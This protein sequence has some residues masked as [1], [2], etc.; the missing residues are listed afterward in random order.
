MKLKIYLFKSVTSTNDVALKKIKK[1]FAN[2]IIIAK[3]Q[4]KGRGR[5][6]KNWISMKNNLFMSIFFK[7]KSKIELKKLTYKIC[8][9]VQESLKKLIKKNIQIKKPND[10]LIDKKKICGILQETIFYKNTKYAIVGIGINIDRSPK[11]PNYPTS[12][13]NF[14]TKKKLTSIKI[15]NEIRN[16]F[17]SYLNKENEYSR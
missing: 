12:Y 14:Y 8:K 9:L 4:S 2:G 7:I 5:Y 6:G 17:E 15:Y 11:I 10:L 1:G 13:L 16:N 3:K